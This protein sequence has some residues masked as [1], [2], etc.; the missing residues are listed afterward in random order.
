MGGHRVVLHMNILSIA[1]LWGIVGVNT[2]QV[3]AKKHNTATNDHYG[4]DVRSRVSNQPENTHTH[5]HTH[6]HTC[7]TC[8]MEVVEYLHVHR[9]TTGEKN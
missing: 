8:I 6:T 2:K 9:N 1:R 5:T 3:A 4:V 7:K